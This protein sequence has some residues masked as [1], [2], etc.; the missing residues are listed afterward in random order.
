MVPNRRPAG[1]EESARFRTGRIVVFFATLPG[2][3]LGWIGNLAAAVLP[4][5]LAAIGDAAGALLEVGKNIM[6]AGRPSSVSSCAFPA[7]TLSRIGA[8]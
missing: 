5:G 7:S 6:R 8:V 4:K 3:I 2:R 1:T